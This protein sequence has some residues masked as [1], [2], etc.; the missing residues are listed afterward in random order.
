M[1][2]SGQDVRDEYFKEE[3]DDQYAQ[4]ATQQG[5]QMVKEISIRRSAEQTVQE[6]NRHTTAR[7]GSSVARQ[8]DQRLNS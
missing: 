2:K 4:K 3:Q 5:E 8:G 7:T 1:E 6:L